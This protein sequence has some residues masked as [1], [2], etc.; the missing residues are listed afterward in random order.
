MENKRKSGDALDAITT[1]KG[2]ENAD[3]GVSGMKNK[4]TSCDLAFVGSIAQRTDGAMC[5]GTTDK[6]VRN[7]ENK[8]IFANYDM[9]YTMTLAT[10]IMANSDS[11]SYRQDAGRVIELIGMAYGQDENEIGE[12]TQV[13]LGPMMQMGL[14]TDQDAIYSRRLGVA[15]TMTE[16]DAMMDIKGDALQQ[17]HRMSEVAACQYNPHW[18]SY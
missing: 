14:V 16:W 4:R 8:T 1:D 12:Y 5:V 11:G 7:T 17:L 3:K 15:S 13:I 10:T 6:G 2:T 9:L 18:F